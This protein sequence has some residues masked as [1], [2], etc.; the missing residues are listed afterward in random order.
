MNTNINQ[1]LAILIAELE[2]NIFYMDL[3]TVKEDIP[4]YV[5]Q[6]MDYDRNKL[7]K[8]SELSSAFIEWLGI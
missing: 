1:S 7:C 8:C 5:E 6:H 3:I 2:S 4:L